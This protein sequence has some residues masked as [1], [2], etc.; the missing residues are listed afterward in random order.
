VCHHVTAT[1]GGHGAA[2]EF[3]DLLLVARGVYASLLAGHLTTLDG[4]PAA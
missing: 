1:P 3:C 4:T 2:R